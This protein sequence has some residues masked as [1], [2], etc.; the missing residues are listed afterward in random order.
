MRQEEEH[1]VVPMLRSLIRGFTIIWQLSKSAAGSDRFSRSYVSTLSTISLVKGWVIWFIV[2]ISDSR[3]TAGEHISL[4][5]TPH[6]PALPRNL[7]W[8]FQQE[9]GNLYYYPEIFINLSMVLWV[10]FIQFKFDIGSSDIPLYLINAG[11]SIITK[12]T[13]QLHI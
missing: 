5:F 7:K 9:R 2:A 12:V 3:T 13:E 1:C 8:G 4:V 11:K 10:Q 6:S